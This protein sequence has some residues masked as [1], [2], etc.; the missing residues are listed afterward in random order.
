MKYL[1]EKFKMLSVGVMAL[2]FLMAVTLSSCGTISNDSDDDESTETVEESAESTEE[3]PAG[4][5]EEHPAGDS[6]EHPSDSTA[7]EA[8][9][10]E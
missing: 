8:E 3:H 1:I 10:P 9:H 7:K 2:S 5:S 4:D 6:E